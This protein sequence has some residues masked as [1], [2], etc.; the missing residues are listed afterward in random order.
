MLTDGGVRVPFVAAWPGTLPAGQVFDQ[1]VSSLDVAATILARQ[2][3]AGEAGTLKDLDGVDLL[4]HVTGQ[5]TG[6]VHPQLFWRWRSQAAVL[7]FPW[8]LIQLGKEKRYLFDITEPEGETRN[9]LAEQPQLAARLQALLSDWNQ[10]L[11]RPGPAEP[12]NE[13]DRGFFA[14]H[15]DPSLRAKA[16]A[17][18]DPDAG[19][20][21]RNGKLRIRDG[22][23]VLQPDAGARNAFLTRSQ[24]RVQGPVTAR[25]SV[26]TTSPGKATLAWRTAKQTDFVATHRVGFDLTAGDDWQQIDVALPETDN[27][28]HLRLHAPPGGL[29]LRSLILQPAKGAAVPL[30]KSPP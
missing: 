9:R 19:W 18:T 11:H 4:P 16:K 8:K 14:D 27:L 5:K 3:D 12:Y 25:L 1:P 13:Q 23:L 7:E 26:K 20:L 2:T 10:N 29:Q 21:A 17:P 15:V 22:V 24:F 28:I 6:P 30:W